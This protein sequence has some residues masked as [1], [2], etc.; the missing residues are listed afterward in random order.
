MTAPH[1]L[2]GGLKASGSHAYNALTVGSLSILAIGG[3]GDTKP[4]QKFP[5]G[6]VETPS[7]G[8]GRFVINGSN[9]PACKKSNTV[10]NTM[11]YESVLTAFRLDGIVSAD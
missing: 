1:F 7:G 4:T 9:I 3:T 11:K 10:N 8:P 6:L 2:S 5:S